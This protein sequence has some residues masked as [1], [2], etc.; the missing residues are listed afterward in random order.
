VD[1]RGLEIP[2]PIDKGQKQI[3]SLQKLRRL[4]R[5]HMTD[6]ADMFIDKT[7]TRPDKILDNRSGQYVLKKRI[8]V[9]FSSDLYPH[10][11]TLNTRTITPRE[12]ESPRQIIGFGSVLA[13]FL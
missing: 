2:I 6:I 3:T 5:E 4:Q 10:S 11:T 1:S 13:D 12:Y 7:P 8:H 9:P